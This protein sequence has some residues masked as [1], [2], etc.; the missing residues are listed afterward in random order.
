MGLVIGL[1]V[2]ISSSP[3]FGWGT[4][5]LV[6][7]AKKK[8]QVHPYRIARP[9]RPHPTVHTQPSLPTMDLT[10]PFLLNGPY[11]SVQGGS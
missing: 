3:V 1:H 9:N 4:E 2:H 5:L 11:F 10:Q 7:G 8:Y 6:L